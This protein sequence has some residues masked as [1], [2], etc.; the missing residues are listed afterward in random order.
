MKKEQRIVILVL[1]LAVAVI[2]LFAVNALIPQQKHGSTNQ[3]KPLTSTP[4]PTEETEEKRQEKSMIVSVDTK[5]KN[6]VYRSLET[7]EHC[8]EESSSSSINIFQS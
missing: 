8:S 1:L 7:G 2:L 6:I 4:I 3:K 5:E